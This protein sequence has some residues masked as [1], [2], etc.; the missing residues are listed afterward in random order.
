MQSNNT[1]KIERAIQQINKKAIKWK[2]HILFIL[3]MIS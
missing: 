1:D 3:L 2:I